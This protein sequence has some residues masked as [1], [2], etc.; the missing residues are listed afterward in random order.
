MA[1]SYG[2]PGASLRRGQGEARRATELQATADRLVKELVARMYVTGRGFYGCL[3]NASH[4]V[5]TRALHDFF[6]IGT[7][8]CGWP[9]Q[10]KCA[11]PPAVRTEM[12]EWSQNESMT[13]DWMRAWSPEDQIGYM[14]RPKTGIEKRKPL[15]A[16]ADRAVISE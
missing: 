2:C 4:R 7:C 6:Y 3:Y 10:D 16:V 12:V 9:E 8:V 14:V 11:L 13:A 1:S 15:P 5:E